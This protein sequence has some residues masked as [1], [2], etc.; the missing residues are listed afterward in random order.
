MREDINPIYNNN[1]GIAFQWKRNTTRDTK[2]IQMVF[3]NTGLLL[4]KE[5][6]QQFSL[7]I[8]CSLAE[9]DQSLCTE[10]SQKEYC[11]SLLLDTPAPQVTLA[12]SYKE[13]HAV[14]DLVDG[15]LFQL[16]LDNFIDGIV[17]N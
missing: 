9:S 3:R 2:K 4:T 11:R 15:T 8:R 13:L 16:N 5:E 10:C 6:L 12:M 1:F 7:N 14:R 17:K